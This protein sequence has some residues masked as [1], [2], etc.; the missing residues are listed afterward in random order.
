V[1]IYN[2]IPI[3]AANG[4]EL[5]GVSTEYSSEK[6]GGDVSNFR[7]S[8]TDASNSTKYFCKLTSHTDFIIE[9]AD[10]SGYDKTISGSGTISSTNF[11]ISGT[12]SQT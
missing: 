8:S 5:Q 1:I 11:R 7:T 4:I 10:V 6:N 3:I 9:N 12:I 2:V